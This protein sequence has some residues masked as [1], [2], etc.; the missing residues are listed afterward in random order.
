MSD[1]DKQSEM[2]RRVENILSYTNH[3]SFDW[4]YCNHFENGY[5][6]GWTDALKHAPEVLALIEALKNLKHDLVKCEDCLDSWN[7]SYEA[8]TA[9]QKA[10]EGGK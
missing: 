7:T 1:R 8:L 6:Q 5:K 3:A 9:Y 2:E 4:P 10:T